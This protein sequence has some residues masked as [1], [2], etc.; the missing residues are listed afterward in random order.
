MDKDNEILLELYKVYNGST[1][2]VS[3]KR[4]NT[5]SF[6]LSLNTGIIAILGFLLN[7]D[8]PS[9]L[10]YLYL[11]MPIVGILSGIFWL[12]LVISYR[13]L[14]S[15]KYKTLSKIEEKLPFAPFSEEWEILGKG[16]DHRKYHPLT[17]IEKGIPITFIAIF[18]SLFIYLLLVF[19]VVIK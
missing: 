14:N 9:Y 11:L 13:Q 5:N 19:L 4:Q 1:E 6:F 3:Q 8:T 17:N 15:G 7:K 12:K 10:K 16:N 18:S 2:N